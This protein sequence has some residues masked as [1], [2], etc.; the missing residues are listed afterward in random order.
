M[1]N[2]SEV[3]AAAGAGESG[4][5]TKQCFGHALTQ[6]PHWIQEN[7]LM[8]HV[9]SPLETTMELQGHV[10]WHTPHKMHEST[11]MSTVPFSP[12]GAGFF[13]KGYRSVSGFLNSDPKVMPPSLNPLKGT[14]L[15]VQL[16]QGSIVRM[17][18]FTS[19]RSQ[20]AN[21]MVIPARF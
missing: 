20:P 14:Y 21:A 12:A 18:M 9:L 2:V 10:L 4:S 17:I 13:S 15:S 16:T 3:M 6:E 8:V 5:I 7:R 11:N 19:A 1:E